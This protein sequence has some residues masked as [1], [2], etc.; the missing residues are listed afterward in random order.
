MWRSDRGVTGPA[1]VRQE[2]IPALNR[3]FSDA[4]TDR[5]RRDGLHGVRVPYLNP[6][7]WRYAIANAGDGAFVWRDGRGALVAFNLAH[8]SGREGWMGPLAVRQDHQGRGLGRTIVQEGI[9]WLQASGATTIG[10]ETM[11]RTVD[12]IGFYSRLGFQPGPLTITLQGTARRM[13]RAFGTALSSLDPDNQRSA[14]RACAD[15]VAS[16]GGAGDYSREA[17][18]TLDLGLGDVLLDVDESG[19][20]NGFAVWHRAALAQDRPAEDG[21]VLKLVARDTEGGVSLIRGV[22]D[23]AA[24][25][26]LPGVSLRCQA[27]YGELYQALIAEDFQVQWTDLRMV[28]ASHPAPAT[29]GVILSNWEI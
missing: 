14:I 18:L 25:I 23:A 28:L 8:R 20:I 21:R 16:L 7:V 12:N 1:I 22:G 29:S 17:R 10:L 24:R 19:N 5:Y 27:E 11:P 9:Q 13:G 15:L 4:F 3:L 26:G 6:L 2:D